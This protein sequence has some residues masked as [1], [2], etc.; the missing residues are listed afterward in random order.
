MDPHYEATVLA[1]RPGT[2]TPEGVQQSHY[3]TGQ[4]GAGAGLS[5]EVG[6]DFDLGKEV[7]NSAVHDSP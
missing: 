4:I 7:I 5:V 6:E 1:G 2:H 3:S